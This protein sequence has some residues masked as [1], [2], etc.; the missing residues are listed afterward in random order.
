MLLRLRGGGGQTL[1]E[2]ALLVALIAI[3]VLAG[4]LLFGVNVTS[5]FS[6]TAAH[7]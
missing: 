4:A 5:L 1:A 7:V 6:N 2:Y 3:V